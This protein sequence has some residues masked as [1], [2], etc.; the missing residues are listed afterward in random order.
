MVLTLAS[1]ELTVYLALF[2]SFHLNSLEAPYNDW[3][4]LLVFSAATSVIPVLAP[5]KHI[6]L[7]IS[8]LGYL[9][10]LLAEQ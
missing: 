10:E 6:Y 1:A 9:F 7:L 8:V 5:I 4:V 2:P 3:S